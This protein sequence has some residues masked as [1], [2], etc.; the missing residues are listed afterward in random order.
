MI[1]LLIEYLKLIFREAA[2]DH[3]RLVEILVLDVLSIKH[4]YVSQNTHYH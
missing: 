4:K 1:V 2:A 3:R